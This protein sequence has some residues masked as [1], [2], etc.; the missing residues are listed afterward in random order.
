MI[1]KLKDLLMEGAKENAALDYLKNLIKKSPYE[2]KVF[3]AGGAVR[4]ELMGIDAKDLD[5]VINM[6]NGGIK[7][8]N[9]AT[10]K[11]KNHKRGSNPVT[12]ERFGTAKF[13]LVGIEHNGFKLDDIDVECVMPRTEEYEDGSRKPK[14][15]SG[16][17][18]DDVERRDFTTNSLLKNLSTG[19]I[20]DLTGMGKSDIKKGI[21]RTPL[22]PDI[23]FS[24]DPLR[25]LRAVRFTMKYNWDLPWFM[26]KA[27]K[28]NASKLKQ[29]SV[30]RVQEE[31]NKMLMTDSPDR[32]I[33][34]LQVVGLSKYVFPE[35][36]KLIKLEQNKYHKED[37]MQHTLTVVKGTP[38]NLVTRL[39]ALF[40]DIGKEA[41]KE[42]IDNEIHFYNHEKIGAE[43]TEK[44]L[45]RLK[46]PND[47]VDAVVKGVANH[48]KLKHGGPD[49]FG[50]SDKTLR[51]FKVNMGEHLEDILNLIHADNIAHESGFDMPNQIEAIRK[52]LDSLGVP[53]GKLKLPI[54]GDDIKKKLKLKPGPVIGD[55]LRIVLD[56]Y[57]ENPKV[58]ARKIWPKLEKYLEDHP[59]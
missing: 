26:I 18:E 46:Y 57:M 11:M 50:A 35:L 48:M 41:T 36:D 8:A 1:I 3:L 44:I 12:F 29:I 43:M 9:W 55:L 45:K 39:M 54:N 53:Q 42:V 19:E 4:D 38:K 16:T 32:A 40:H 34:L 10:K 31:L 15:G 56:E 25:M 2:G 24:E 27:L 47:I 21:I 59:Q 58:T 23:I 37:A 14:V 22:D 6:K 17:L 51:K 13:N 7:F 52:R 30:E 49:S 20:L 5:F 33:R 28:R